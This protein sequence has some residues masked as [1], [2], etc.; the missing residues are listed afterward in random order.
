MT[1][2]MKKNH[3][4]SHQADFGNN[5]IF[6]SEKQPKHSFKQS[7]EQDV[8]IE[9]SDASSESSEISRRSNISR[10]S[11][12]SKNSGLNKV[13]RK[14]KK[15]KKQSKTIE[16]IF[17]AQKCMDRKDRTAWDPLMIPREEQI[18]VY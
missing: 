15:Q 14:I 13:M 3:S 10:H 1:K 17:K 18:Q 9:Y 11:K 12:A 4:I 7:E 6:V 5:A 16:K 8:E 2:K